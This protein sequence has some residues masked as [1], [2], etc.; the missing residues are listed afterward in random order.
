MLLSCSVM[1]VKMFSRRE[2]EKEKHSLFS[3]LNFA[4][5][6]VKVP[7]LKENISFLSLFS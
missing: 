1:A 7:F 5:Y 4:V 6:C 3:Q 2:E